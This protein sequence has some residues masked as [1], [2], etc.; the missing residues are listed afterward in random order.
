MQA[1]LINA[2]DAFRLTTTSSSDNNFTNGA[3]HLADAM[4]TSF[5]SF[6]E[7]LTNAHVAFCLTSTTSSDNNFTSGAIPPADAMMT[8]FSSLHERLTNVSVAFHL[9]TTAYPSHH[10]L[11]NDIIFVANA[12]AN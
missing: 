9:T 2:A 11:T 7:R 4:M 3:I 8:L 5:S 10:N 1:S 12:I 6:H